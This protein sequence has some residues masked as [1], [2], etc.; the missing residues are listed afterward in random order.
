MVSNDL[1]V[2][3]V[4]NKSMCFVSIKVIWKVPSF[5]TLMDLIL[6]PTGNE[7]VH[8]SIRC[9]LWEEWISFCFVFTKQIDNPILVVCL[10]EVSMRALFKPVDEITVD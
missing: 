1:I 9:G 10:P 2:E 4:E 8:G 5:R 6:K 7:C 3:V